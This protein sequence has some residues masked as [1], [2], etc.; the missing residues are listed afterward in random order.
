[1]NNDVESAKDS[2]DESVLRRLGAEDGSDEES[3]ASGFTD[4]TEKAPKTAE[5]APKSTAEAGESAKKQS[6]EQQEKVSENNC[7]SRMMIRK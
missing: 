4:A 3:V 5:K 7:S 1:M 6:E 2:D